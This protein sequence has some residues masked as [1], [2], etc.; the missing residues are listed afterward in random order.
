MCGNRVAAL[1]NKLHEPGSVCDLGQEPPLRCVLR[2]QPWTTETGTALAKLVRRVSGD[3]IDKD[4]AGL[5][6]TR[7]PEV[8]TVK[9]NSEAAGRTPLFCIL[10]SGAA[11]ALKRVCAIARR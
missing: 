5:F 4:A 10:K 8:P 11:G 1:A 6:V 7:K 3:A 2:T 9:G